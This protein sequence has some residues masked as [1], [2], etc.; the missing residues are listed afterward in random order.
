MAELEDYIYFYGDTGI[1]IKDV[2]KVELEIL[3]EFD[4][5]CRKNNIPYQLFAGTLLGAIRHKAFI[6]WDDDIDVVLKRKDFE[7]FLLCCQKDLKDNFFLQ[8]CFTDPT[9]VV[10]FAKIRK[11]GTVYE[12]DVDNLPTSHTGIWIDIF[13]LD[14]VKP[15][16]I[17]TKW[18]RFEIQLLYAIV[19]AS[20]ESRI[21]A[22]PKLWKRVV[23]RFFSKILYV[24]PKSQ[25]DKCLLRIYKRYDEEDTGLISFLTLGAEKQH[26]NQVL[27]DSKKFS[28]VI[29]IDFCGHKFFGPKHYDEILRHHYGDYMKLPPKEKRVPQH[30]VT[31]VRI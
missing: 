31:R 2:Q 21:N 16:S 10:Q 20:V 28:D 23:R 1:S 27:Q 29:E 7:Q 26:F 13:P 24:I 19:T 5:I 30:G 22:S 15:E 6:P 18:Q 3:L 9:S 12:N 14:N 11:N 8:T 25:I 17:A 4:R